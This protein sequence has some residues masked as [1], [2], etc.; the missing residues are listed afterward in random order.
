MQT[1]L[2]NEILSDNW[3]LQTRKFAHKTFQNNNNNNN[4]AN[5]AANKLIFQRRVLSPSGIWLAISKTNFQTRRAPSKEDERR[6]RLKS[7][8][9]RDQT[10]NSPAETATATSLE[11]VQPP[12]TFF[13]RTESR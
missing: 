4:T 3:Q 13:L 11:S 7:C 1:L 12:T 10:E 9:R 8:A 2:T 5:N 6:C